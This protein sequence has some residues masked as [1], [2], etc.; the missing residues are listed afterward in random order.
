M[1][2]P[3]NHGQPVIRLGAILGAQWVGPD[4]DL[5][6]EV[7]L[8]DEVGTNVVVSFQ[9]ANVN[10][11]RIGQIVMP[12]SASILNISDETCIAHARMA[13]WIEGGGVGP[14]PA[15]TDWIALFQDEG[16]IPDFQMAIGNTRIYDARPVDDIYF[17][18]DIRK[19]GTSSP[20]KTV[21]IDY[22]TFVGYS[23]EPVEAS[24]CIAGGVKWRHPTY[25]HEYPGTIL[26]QARRDEIIATILSQDL[27]T[28]LNNLWM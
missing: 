6:L 16:S 18:F 20:T 21:L 4:D 12:N 23:L 15:S 1:P 9:T 13:P 25:V 27:N 8:L 19:K 14:S 7:Q 24:R 10:E 2:A 26:T 3:Y 22:E 28:G 11:G 5:A 17:E